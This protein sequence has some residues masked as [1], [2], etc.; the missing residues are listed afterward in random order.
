MVYW[1]KEGYTI[2]QVAAELNV[3]EAILLIELEDYNK[4]YPGRIEEYYDRFYRS[5]DATYLKNASFGNEFDG[6]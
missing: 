4:L 6:Q 3:P 5:A 1:L 2:S